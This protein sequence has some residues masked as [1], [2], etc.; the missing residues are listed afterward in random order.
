MKKLIVFLFLILAGQGAL[1]IERIPASPEIRV[2]VSVSNIQVIRFPRK[3]LE[4][5]VDSSKGI[6]VQAQGNNLLIKWNPYYH[7]PAVIAVT[8][9]DEDGNTYD[10]SVIAVP[11]RKNPEVVEIYIP[12]EVRLRKK[13]AYYERSMP[14]EEFL[15]TLT[16]Q[17]MSGNYP[18]YYVVRPKKELLGLFAE[19]EVWLTAEGVGDR[20]KVLKGYV[21]NILNKQIRIDETV[22]SFLSKRF[23]VRSISVHH[24]LLN[25]DEITTFVVVVVGRK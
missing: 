6:Q 18:D 16:K 22:L 13:A 9:Q 8:T 17:F 23:D 3:V 25:P 15:V 2:S 7:K 24:H 20:F 11:N 4:A 10:Y 1:A 5:Y 12:E 19:L 21:R 14:Y